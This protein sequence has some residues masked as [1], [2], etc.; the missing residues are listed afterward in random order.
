MRPWRSSA[1]A[2]VMLPR[3]ALVAYSSRMRARPRSSAACSISITVTGMPALA[4]H[5]AMPPPMVPAP[6]T[7]AAWTGRGS[8]PGGSG[9]FCASRSAKKAWRWARLSSPTTSCSNSRRSLAAPSSKGIVTAART[10]STQARGAWAPLAF[11]KR[12]GQAVDQAGVGAGG[13]QLVLPVAHAAAVRHRAGVLDGGAGIGAVQQ[14]VHQPGGVRLLGADGGAG[15]DHGQRLLDPDDARQA[16]RAAGAGQEAEL[17]LGQA[18][19]GAGPGGAGVAAQC[20]FQ[21]AAQ[22]H[23]VHGGYD[24]DRHVLDRGDDLAQ[25]GV[26]RGVAELGDVSA[27]AEGAGGAGEDDG[28]DRGVP[29]QAVQGGHEALA[30]APGP[31]R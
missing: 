24:G 7:A 1:W 13:L 9:A 27:A 6:M 11:S 10:L 29:A 28:L 17:D 31:G 4:K 16:L 12:G 23:A 14:G 5:M 20:Q 18:H 22:G 21:P 15:D 2:S 25:V 30:A 3:L 19:L 8:V 26:L